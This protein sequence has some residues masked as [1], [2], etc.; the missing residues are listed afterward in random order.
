MLVSLGRTDRVK[1]GII[2]EKDDFYKSLGAILLKN[3]SLSSLEA[4]DELQDTAIKVIANFGLDFKVFLNVDGLLAKLVEIAVDPK[5]IYDKRR[6][7]IF[8]LK[9]L[10]FDCTE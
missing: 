9:N 10:G 7:S 5:C 8:A 3:D 1:K 6:N 2:C 4:S